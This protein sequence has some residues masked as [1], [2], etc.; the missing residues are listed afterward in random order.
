[1]GGD[2]IFT[3]IYGHFPDIIG[4]LPPSNTGSAEEEK[5]G[6]RIVTFVKIEVNRILFPY[7]IGCPTS[8]RATLPGGKSEMT[9]RGNEIR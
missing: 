7:Y 4:V 1:M 5:R 2:S 3:L 8:K 9:S 6:R